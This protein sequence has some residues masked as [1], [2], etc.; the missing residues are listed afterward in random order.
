M[1]KDITIK[2]FERFKQGNQEAFCDIYKIYYNKL[3][4]FGS[5]FSNDYNLVE[6]VIQDFFI[7]MFK[8]PDKLNH[9]I[10]LEVYL[11]KSIKQN[12][13]SELNKENRRTVIRKLVID[14]DDKDDSIEQELIRKELSQERILWLKSHIDSLPIRQKE[15]I[16]L[17]FYEGLSYDQITQLTSLSNQVARNYVSRALDKLRHK[18]LRKQK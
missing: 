16:Y 17:R 12:I 5:I 11:F 2:L 13:I 15:I 8:T 18:M 9:V 14:L 4:R 10:N 6:N 7:K 1:N 3:L